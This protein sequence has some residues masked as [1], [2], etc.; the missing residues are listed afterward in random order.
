MGSDDLFKKM[1]EDR[2]RKSLSRI[3]NTRVLHRRILIVC[4]GEKTEPYYFRAFRIPT[5]EIVVKGEGK[6]ADRL[7]EEAIGYINSSNPDEPYDDVWCVFDKDDVEWGKIDR[8]F[9]LAKSNNINIA[10]TNGAFELWYLLHFEYL[11]SSLS[12]DRY[13]VK[14]THHL[15]NMIPQKSTKGKA[16]EVKYKKNDE[17]MFNILRPYQR[18]AIKNAEKLIKDH[19]GF[20]PRHNPV[21]TVHLLVNDLIKEISD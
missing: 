7:V 3:E 9:S 4:E 13:M 6:Q 20:S 18:I 15:K 8:A 17:N 16:N 5:L 2:K 11:V 10:Y 12:R 19:N 21:T 1:R 14:L